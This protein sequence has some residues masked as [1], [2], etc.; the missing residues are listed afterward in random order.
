MYLKLINTK[1]KLL[2]VRAGFDGQ[3]G[4]CLVSISFTY[5]V[6]I[7]RQMGKIKTLKLETYVSI[8][9]MKS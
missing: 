3:M 1:I 9:C 2:L 6:S 7:E 5:L 4:T 8:Y